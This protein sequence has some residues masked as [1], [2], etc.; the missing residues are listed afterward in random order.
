M[1]YLGRVEGDI[2]DSDRDLASSTFFF[3]FFFRFH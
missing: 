2:D 3:F 1:D